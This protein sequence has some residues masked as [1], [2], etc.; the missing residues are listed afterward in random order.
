MKI[1]CLLI[2]I[3]ILCVSSAVLA[4]ENYLAQVPQLQETAHLANGGAKGCGHGTF[5]LITSNGEITVSSGLD[6]IHVF[7]QKIAVADLL[8]L[9]QARVDSNKTGI[10]NPMSGD[11]SDLVYVIL[12]IFSQS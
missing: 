1:T 5:T 11:V 6:P 3:L 8:K 12:S 7:G 4:Q 9:I 10:E 2:L